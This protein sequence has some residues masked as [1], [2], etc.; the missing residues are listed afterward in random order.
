[1]MF[2]QLRAAKNKNLHQIS[3]YQ[4]KKNN[5]QKKVAKQ[6]QMLRTF[7]IIAFIELSQM[8]HIILKID[9]QFK[10]KEQPLWRLN[11]DGV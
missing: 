6:G 3:R 7:S 5:N 11:L 2:P 8:K 1:M 9:K 10:P 4:K